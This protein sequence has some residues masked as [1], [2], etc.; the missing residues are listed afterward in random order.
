V[1]RHH[2]ERLDG[3][4]YPD[5]LRGFQIPP[6]ARI[7]AV[8]DMYDAIIAARPYRRAAPQRQALDTLSEESGTHLD[9]AL[10]LAFRGSYSGVFRAGAPVP[11]CAAVCGVA[12]L[13][14]DGAPR[15]IVIPLH[16]SRGSHL[17]ERA[18]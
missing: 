12:T 13:G 2:H 7:I 16:A 15:Q 1:V 10:V 14:P 6:G 8:A 11:V 3:T 17:T 4:G 5:G 18:L 9:P